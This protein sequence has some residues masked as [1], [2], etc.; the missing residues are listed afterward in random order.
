VIILCRQLS[1]SACNRLTLTS[2]GDLRSVRI[3]ISQNSIWNGEKSAPSGFSQTLS[4][5]PVLNQ[6][7]RPSGFLC[8]VYSHHV[9]HRNGARDIDLPRRSL[10]TFVRDGG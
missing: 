6:Y 3:G 1:V 5:V 7:V 9:N 8:S 4:L 2:N 10:L